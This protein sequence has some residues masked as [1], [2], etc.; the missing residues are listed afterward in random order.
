MCFHI[1]DFC[2]NNIISIC[3][4]D[5]FILVN[6]I[7]IIEIDQ[8]NLFCIEIVLFKKINNMLEELLQ[9]LQSEHGLSAEQSSG[10]LNT[11]S[12]FVKEKFPMMAGMIDNILPSGTAVSN[13]E[14]KAK[15]SGSPDDGNIM[16]KISEI[17]PAG[18]GEKI[19]EIAKDKL[20]GLFGK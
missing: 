7:F 11:I 9:K 13:A 18:A 4:K 10:I 2:K 15:T 17:L 20:G 8:N 19:E 6:T 16:D 3:C 5:S 12:S 14:S 1:T